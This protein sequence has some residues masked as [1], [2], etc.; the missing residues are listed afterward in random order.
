MWTGLILLGAFWAV[1][2]FA[3]RKFVRP[4]TRDERRYD[5]EAQ[6]EALDQWLAKENARHEAL[7]GATDPEI[8]SR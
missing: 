7:Q 8:K 1:F 5:D 3:W 2:P 4:P 6:R